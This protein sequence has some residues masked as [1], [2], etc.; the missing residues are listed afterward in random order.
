VTFSYSGTKAGVDTIVATLPN[1][2]GVTLTSNS[3]TKE[4]TGIGEPPVQERYIY[5]AKFVCGSIPG[6]GDAAAFEEPP[7]KPGNYA[8]AINIQNVTSDTSTFTYR[9]SVARAVD[10]EAAPGP[11][12]SAA[13]AELDRF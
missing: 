9:T 12:S 3:M 7:V 11:V 5:S 1:G 10:P 13:S 6:S 8:T 2:Q 4:W